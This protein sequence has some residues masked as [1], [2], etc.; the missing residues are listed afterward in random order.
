MTDAGERWRVLYDE[1]CGLCKWLLSGLLRWDSGRRLE[2]LGLRRPEAGE[3]LRELDPGERMS[4]WHLIAPTGGRHSAGA[5]LPPL[6]RQLPGGRV[7]AAA[8]ARFP[9][10]TER[11]YRWVADHRAQL[12]KLV[13]DGAKQRASERVRR[14]EPR[15]P[16]ADL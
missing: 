15:S 5:A 16:R 9:L 7:P 11:G 4:S 12:S 6:L 14:R 13:P 1:E 3:L 2:P 8:F 10:L